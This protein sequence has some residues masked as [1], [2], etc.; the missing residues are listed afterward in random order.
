MKPNSRMDLGSLIGEYNNFQQYWQEN[1]EEELHRVDAPHQHQHRHLECV[2]DDSKNNL[3]IR[4]HAGRAKGELIS[5]HMFK[6]ENDTILLDGK[7]M[8]NEG[9]LISNAEGFIRIENGDI[10]FSGLEIL[11]QCGSSPYV[12]KPCRYFSGWIQYPPNI[13]QPDELYSLR[14]LE[15]HDQGGYVELDVEGVDYTVELTQLVYA[16]TLKIMKLAVYDIP[17]SEV[18][19]N[20]KA[21]CYTW[22]EPEA[23]RLGINI[24]KVL[25]GW[26]MIEPGFVNSNNLNKNS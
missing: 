8:K 24:R 10:H 1:T 26:T 9:D 17:M 15:I 18:G 12:F 16:K 22:A 2:Y 19:I 6:V 11:E 14:D 5:E 23:K 21:I 3:I 13:E 7:Q 4:L 25:S 20:S